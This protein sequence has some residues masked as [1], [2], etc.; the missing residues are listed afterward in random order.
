M[1][2]NLRPYGARRAAGASRVARVHRTTTAAA[3]LVTVAVSALTG[4]TTVQSPP[5]G[6]PAAPSRPAQ[7]RPS[8]HAATGAVQAPARE[9]L[10]PVEESRRPEPKAAP[11]R[12][13]APD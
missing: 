1:R 4:C 7:S 11:S 5:A 6:P 2:T 8:E 13:A 3:L 10:A 12:R 9:A